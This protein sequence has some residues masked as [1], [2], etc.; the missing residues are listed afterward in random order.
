MK[1]IKN[2][3]LFIVML[4]TVSSCELNSF[5][6]ENFE[7]RPEFSQSG[8]GND[9]EEP[10]IQGKVFEVSGGPGIGALIEL[11]PEGDTSSVDF[12]VADSL[13]EYILWPDSGSYFLR[14]SLTGYLEVTSDTF[15][16][17]DTVTVN[18]LLE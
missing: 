8:G 5:E 9:D 3:L 6:E 17:V 10:I 11:V 13:G 16:A 15:K 1:T 4:V 2:A 14:V 7:V 18:V 12:T